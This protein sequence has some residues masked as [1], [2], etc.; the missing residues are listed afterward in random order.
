VENSGYP[1]DEN[2]YPIPRSIPCMA[3]PTDCS[4]STNC[5]QNCEKKS[6][7]NW[8][9]TS[10]GFCGWCFAG[11]GGGLTPFRILSDGIHLMLWCIPSLHMNATSCRGINPPLAVKT[12]CFHMNQMD[13]S[14]EKQLKNMI[15]LAS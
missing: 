14:Y 15:L 11:F 12:I 3:S 1:P 13:I 9:K 5:I 2:P 8:Q 10:V 6:S 7:F 4:P